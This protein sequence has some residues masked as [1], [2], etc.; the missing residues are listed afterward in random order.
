MPNTVMKTICFGIKFTNRL[1]KY[2][3]RTDEKKVIGI[4][5]CGSRVKSVIFAQKSGKFQ[6]VGIFTAL[7]ASQLLQLSQ[8]PQSLR[9]PSVAKKAELPQIFTDTA[10]GST[11]MDNS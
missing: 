7:T 5:S 3:K 6:R 2:A 10:D 11:A 8:L 1:S 4:L 9:H